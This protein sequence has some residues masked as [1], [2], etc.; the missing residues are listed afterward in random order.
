MVSTST[1]ARDTEKPWMVYKKSDRSRDKLFEPGWAGEL[2]EEETE[3][4]QEA[5]MSDDQLSYW[6]GWKPGMKRRAVA[7]IERVAYFGSPESRAHNVKLVREAGRRPREGN[8]GGSSRV[9]KAGAVSPPRLGR[10]RI[11]SWESEMLRLSS[12]GCGVKRIAE[13]LRGDGVA[14]SHMTVARRLKELRGQLSLPL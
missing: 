8:E 11:E 9:T 4:L 6:W 14:I 2:T 7:A 1:K 13:K 3:R 10:P 5:L 12:Q